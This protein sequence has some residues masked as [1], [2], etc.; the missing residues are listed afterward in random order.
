MKEKEFPTHRTVFNFIKYPGFW[1]R[2]LYM[3]NILAKNMH[4]MEK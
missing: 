2:Y 4:F 3:Q 1:T